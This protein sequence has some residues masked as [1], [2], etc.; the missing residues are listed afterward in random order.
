MYDVIITEDIIRDVNKTHWTRERNTA[1]KRLAIY[2]AE[3]L[4]RQA[5]ITLNPDRIARLIQNGELGELGTW[6]ESLGI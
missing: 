3:L 6:S 1:T 4:E 5:D 2:R